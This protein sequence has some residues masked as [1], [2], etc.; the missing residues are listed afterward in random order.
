MISNFHRGDTRTFTIT[1]KD[2]AGAPVDIT[3][4]VLYMT[5]KVNLS[6]GDPGS[7]QLAGTIT[8]AVNGIGTF[9]LESDKSKNLKGVYYYDM[10][11]A[12]NATPPVVITAESGKVTVLADVT[13]TDT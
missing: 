10:Q 1:V 4:H 12:S 3:D 13:I 7:V 11:A 6:D 8:D 9:L 5:F 2:D